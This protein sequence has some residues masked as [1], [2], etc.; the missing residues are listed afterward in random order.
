MRWSS[1]G[2]AAVV[3]SGLAFFVPVGAPA[4]DSQAEIRAVIRDY[5]AS[6]PEE[7]QRIVRDYIRNNP[8]LL[9]ATLNELM[10]QRQAAAAKTAAATSAQKSAIIKTNET[11]LLRSPHHAVLGNPEGDVT[12]VEF[13]DY[14]C[15]YCKRALSDKLALLQKHPNLRIVLKEFPILGAGSL[16]AARAS[17]A[18]RMQSPAAATYLEFHKRMLESRGPVDRAR[19]FDV[20]REVGLD[21]QRLEQD[22]NADEV[23][24]SLDESMKLAQALGFRGTPS[25][26]VGDNV[27]V[28]AVG[29]VALTN[30][31]NAARK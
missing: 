1:I 7:V 3:A 25:Y 19:A 12:L 15:G 14:N 26:V 29:V 24:A 6:N 30:S 5:L 17:I 10:K 16:E 21:L 13:F 27:V 4:Q 23:R 31:I 2:F 18:A 8:E 28:G 22:M 9:V 20:A 11:A